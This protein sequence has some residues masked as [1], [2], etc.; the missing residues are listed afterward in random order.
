MAITP[1]AVALDIGGRT[2]DLAVRRSARARRIGLRIDPVRANAELVVPRR[3]GLA[4][5]LRFA[6]GKRD[7]LAQRI[8]ALP[9][10]VTFTD[11]ASISVGGETIVIRHDPQTRGAV[12]REGAD[13]IVAGT[14]EHCARRVRDWLKAQARG[15]LDRRS[16]E[17]ALRVGRRVS[18]VR[19]GDPKSRWGSC[20]PEGGLSYSWRLILAPPFVLDRKSTR[21][22]SSH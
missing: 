14:P 13:L 6:D 8:A 5:A 20:S 7:W 11:G 1:E 2:I 3:V 15:M 4:E 9:Q 17:L 16:R 21:L 18:G 19:L 10:A 22:N 12:R